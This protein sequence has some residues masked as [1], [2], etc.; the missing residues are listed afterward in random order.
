MQM[1]RLATRPS[2]VSPRVLRNRCSVLT[3]A[4]LVTVAGTVAGTG[5]GGSR[6]AQRIDR[7]ALQERLGALEKPGLLIGEFAL[8]K[9]LDGDT[10]RV[11]SID[12]SLRLLGIDTEETFKTEG[13]RRLFEDGWQGYLKA[14]RGSSKHPVKMA[15][16]L[17][18]DAKHFAA[19]FFDGSSRGVRIERDDPKELRDVFGRYLAYAF[20]WKREPSER[21]AGDDGGR[22]VNYNVE[23]VRAGMSP[24]FSKYGYSKR[25]H[26][27]FVVAEAEARKAERGIWS[28]AG[29]H[30]P[31]YPERKVWW[32]ARAEFLQQAVEAGGDRKDFILLNHWDSLWRLEKLEN[33]EVTVAGLVAEVK[34]GDR[35]PSRVLLTRARNNPFP[36]IFFDKDVMV[37]SQVSLYRGEFITVRGTVARYRR[38][39][40]SGGNE[41]QIVIKEPGQI[42]GRKL[43]GLMQLYP[44]DNEDA[45]D[46]DAK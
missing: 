25:F 4:L 12:Q 6:R 5:C 19:A 31:D 43:P 20:A 9:V 35:G 23:C 46:R 38:K 2:N 30:Y 21:G 18:E 7:A 32:D 39:D 1:S 36:L 41:L 15:T 33:Q 28:P 44:D 45:P 10:I 34:L 26:A 40:G 16:P 13:D 8:D 27:E 14:K 3:A 29:L 37:A 24:Y 17:G 42:V 11:A 22:W